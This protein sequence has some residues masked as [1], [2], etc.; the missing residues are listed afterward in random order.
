MLIHQN[1]RA[2]YRKIPV[3]ACRQLPPSTEVK[4][5]QHPQQVVAVPA[6]S[7]ERVSPHQAGGLKRDHMLHIQSPQVKSQV[8]QRLARIEGQLRGVQKMIAEDRECK[9]VVQQLVAI[10][11]AVQSASLTFMQ[12]VAS[13]CL[14]NPEGQGDSQAQ[15]ENMADLIALL[16]KLS[17]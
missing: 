14:L 6:R 7:V 13:E 10:R 16:G 9:E 12:N 1:V 4:P 11:S 3:N 8:I 5:R 17:Q 15:R 2:A